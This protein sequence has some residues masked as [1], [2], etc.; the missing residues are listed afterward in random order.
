[1]ADEQATPQGDQ[2]QQQQAAP[3]L[4]IVT[5][6]VKDLSFE[7]PNAP[8]AMQVGKQPKIDISIDLQA[9]KGEDDR[10]EVGLKIKA[11]ASNPD[12]NSR[13][14]LVEL[15]YGGVFLVKNVPENALEA[16]LLIEC[17]RQLFP[18]ARRVIAD[19][20]RDGGYPP[21]M[22]DPVDFAALYRARLAQ[23]QQE[24]Q[25]A[26]GDSIDAPAQGNA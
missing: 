5:Q 6:Y 25:A 17:P 13:I 11:D 19:C 24:Q 26:A 3:Q 15:E 16:V 14:F 1:M 20:T 22:L 8:G 10:Y 2:Q 23:R 21:M 9:R 7:N 18:F 4:S 12:D